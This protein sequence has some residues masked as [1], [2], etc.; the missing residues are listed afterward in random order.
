MRI[1]PRGSYLASAELAPATFTAAAEPPPPLPL[2]VL[3]LNGTLVFR[4][5]RKGSSSSTPIRRPYLSSFLAYCLGVPDASFV[6]DAQE[7]DVD[8]AAFRKRRQAWEDP[9]VRAASRQGKGSAHG[10]H[11]RNVD[12]TLSASTNAQSN[13]SVPTQDSTHPAA[14]YRVLVWSSARPENVDA[15]VRAILHPVQAAQLIRCWARDTLV[16]PRL[17]YE[18]SPSTKDLE[19]VWN[20]V[21]LETGAASAD[22]SSE[23]PISLDDEEGEKRINA[24]YR[25]QQDTIYPDDGVEPQSTPGGPRDSEAVSPPARRQQQAGDAYNAALEAALAGARAIKLP[26]Q[27]EDGSWEAGAGYGAHNTLLLDDS[28]DKAR[29]QPFNHLFI[30][31]FDAVSANKATELRSSDCMR[32]PDADDTSGNDEVMQRPPSP[33]SLQLDGLSR[34]A[35]QRKRAA[36]REQW[37]SY[38][39]QQ[40]QNDKE[41][42]EEQDPASDE[43]LLESGFASLRA[44]EVEEAEPTSPTLGDREPLGKHDGD[45]ILLQTIGV[46]EHARWQRNVAAW[47]KSGGLGW[48]AGVE[49]PGM[50]DAAAEIVDGA[51]PDI[52]A[53]GSKGISVRLDAPKET[54]TT[55]F[56]EEEGRVA[57]RRSGIPIIF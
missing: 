10:T 23:H 35:Q 38:E 26:A 56:W 9:T 50:K 25:D 47:I 12:V 20:A 2:L 53:G 18:K 36:N 15:M 51:S 33:S 16:P 1:S 28:R 57:L 49:N 55:D 46:L 14:R 41:G 8:D 3:D 5:G 19:I 43:K 6:P 13:G 54:R 39:A 24:D 44:N 48:Y 32:S 31:E 30:P 27:R 29:L 17:Y 42:P 7:G 37:A 40:A 34:R 11:F 21:N 4:P 45:T 52:A 22:A